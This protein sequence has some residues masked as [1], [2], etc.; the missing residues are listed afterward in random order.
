MQYAKAEAAS[1]VNPVTLCQRNALGTGCVAD[2]GWQQGWIVF[3]DFDGSQNISALFL[4]TL[5][6]GSSAGARLHLIAEARI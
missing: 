4:Y 1:R 2:G 3:T 6:P 5:P